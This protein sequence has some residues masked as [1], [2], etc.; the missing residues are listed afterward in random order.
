MTEHLKEETE[1]RQYLLGQMTREKQVLVEARL[2]LD[3]DYSDLVQAVA[4]DL[5]DDYVNNDLTGSDLQE[6][7]TY[8][9]TRKEYQDDL[10]IGKALRRFFTSKN[11]VIDPETQPAHTYAGYNNPPQSRV[12]TSESRFR[13]LFVRRPALGF[14]VAAILIILSAIAFVTIQSIR[15]RDGGAPVQAHDQ[16]P[17]QQER[18][19]NESLPVN[20]SNTGKDVSERPAGN[21]G[22]KKKRTKD[23]QTIDHLSNQIANQIPL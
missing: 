17:A 4:D 7:E 14:A 2:F 18:I 3:S 23:K 10:R 12:A 20:S 16:P 1:L 21:E 9:L 19:S 5:I 13:L 15:R 8:F 6:F 11:E 22:H